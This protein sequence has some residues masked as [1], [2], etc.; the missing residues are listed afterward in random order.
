MRTQ[1]HV[2]RCPKRFL[3]GAP[4]HVADIFDDPRTADRYTVFYR[5][6]QQGSRGPWLVY[7]SMSAYPFHP[8][9]IG[10]FGEMELWQLSAYRHE[11]RRF[12]V[13]WADLPPDVQRCVIQD[14]RAK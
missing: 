10:M 8:Q 7:R 3:E 12:R 4:D 2:K 5:E 6:L 9:G 13:R 14:G 11:N 1:R